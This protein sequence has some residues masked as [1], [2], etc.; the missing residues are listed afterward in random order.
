MPDLGVESLGELKHHLHMPVD[1]VFSTVELLLARCDDR[2]LYFVVS[3]LRCIE[4]I[5]SSEVRRPP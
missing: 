1:F 5:C 4:L 3:F 2:S